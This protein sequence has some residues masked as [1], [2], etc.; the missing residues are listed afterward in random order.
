MDRVGP[1]REVQYPL[2]G[3]P[4]RRDARANAGQSPTTSLGVQFLAEFGTLLGLLFDGTDQVHL[5]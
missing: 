4:S 3:N 5:R 1:W 2:V